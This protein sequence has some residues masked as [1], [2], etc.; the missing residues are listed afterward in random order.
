MSLA[1][2]LLIGLVIGLTLGALG[3]GGSILTVPALVYVLGESGQDATTASLVIVGISS[4]ISVASYSR[5]RHVRWRTG[6]L[7]GVTGAGASYAGSL[8]NR[9]VPENL[10]L[11]AFAALMLLAGAAMLV[12]SLRHPPTRRPVPARDLVTAGR[13]GSAETSGSTL[14][15]LEPRTAGRARDDAETRADG[16]RRARRLSV[17]QLVVA[18]VVVGFLTGFLGVGGG[19]LIVPALTMLLGYRMC[20][21]V[22]TSL[23][24]IVFNSVVSLMSR[25]GHQHFDWS[26][27]VPVSLAAILGSLAGKR[28]ADR[29]PQRVLSRAFAILVL[30]VAL[31]MGVRGLI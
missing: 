28:V 23:L 19:F 12:K 17:V 24:I 13:A 14:P 10:L 4:V 11:L 5:D 15:V 6:L 2:G 31:Y 9:S 26:V 22:G 1:L 3:G 29:L 25:V 7:F 8:L 27:I 16:A 18:G 30:L 20:V 21:A